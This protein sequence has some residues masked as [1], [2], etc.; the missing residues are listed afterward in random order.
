M[1]IRYTHVQIF[2][3]T[4]LFRS[5]FYANYPQG[6][7]FYVYTLRGV[8]F[9][10]YKKNA[11]EDA[12]LGFQ[13]KCKLPFFTPLSGCHPCL[14]GEDLREQTAGREAAMFGYFFQGHLRMFGY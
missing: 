5:F 1:H 4:T 3:Q 11:P 14:T 2:T 8:N 12:F 7:N 13:R 9:Y 6:V 10:T